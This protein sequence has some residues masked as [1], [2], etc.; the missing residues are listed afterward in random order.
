MKIE[1]YGIPSEVSRCAGCEYAKK[2]LDSVK[3]TYSFNEVIHKDQND[4]GFSFNRPLIEECAKRIGCFP[5]LNLRYPVIFVDDVKI[6]S[7]KDHLLSL[8]YNLD[9]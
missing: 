4:L 9:D 1:I 7:I 2:L 6:T 3:L 8:G 5:N